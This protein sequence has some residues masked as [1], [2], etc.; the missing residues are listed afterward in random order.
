MAIIDACAISRDV[1]ERRASEDRRKCHPLL[2]DWQYAFGGRRRN[3]RRLDDLQSARMMLDWYRPHLLFFVVATYSMSGIDAVLTLTLLEHGNAIEANPFMHALL[4]H[5][6]G[7]FVAVKSIVT[8]LGLVCLV[9]LSNARL[10]RR[11][12]VEY[13]LYALFAAYV[14]LVTYEIT[15][16]RAV[17]FS[18]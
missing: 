5:S 6:V 18:Y 2:A 1:S 7:L 12:P 8:G 11:I 10:F 9:A 16:L 15:L 14:A 17:T 3:V 4:A 13:I